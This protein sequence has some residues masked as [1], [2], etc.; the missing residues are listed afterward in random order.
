[1]GFEIKRRMYES[2]PLV[3]KRCVGL[4]PFSRVAGRAYRDALTRG[5]L[6]GRAGRAQILAYQEQALGQMLRFAT[7]QVP[8]YRSL[9]GCVERLP[10]FDALREFPLLDKEALQEH[11]ESYLPRDFERIPHYEIS[12]G[13]T[14]GRQ[15]RF[16]VDD[17][18][19][20]VET[21]F[22]HRQWGRVGY[23]PRC[24]KATFRGVSF[25][26]LKPGTHWQANPIYNEIQ[27]SPFH[28]TE[29][30]LA[31]YVDVLAR[32]N[33][34]YLHGYPSAVD[35]LAEYVLRNGLRERLPRIQAALLGSEGLMPG[36]R[37]RIEDAF[38][39]RVYSW[40][41]H[42]ERVILAGE[43]ELNETYHQFP[44]YGIMEIVSE[45]GKRLEREGER[46][47]L[48]G[49]GLLNR[50]LPLI[51]YRTGDYAT[52]CEPHCECGRS[53]DRFTAV[54]GRWKQEMLV[55]RNGA[56][57]SIA[58]LNMHGP[59]FER[60]IRYQYLQ[61]EAGVCE[62]RVLPAPGFSETDRLRIEDAYRAKVGGELELTVRA[63]DGISLTPRGKLPLLISTLGPGEDAGEGRVGALEAGVS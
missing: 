53:W 29:A 22:M 41:G 16:F 40:Y 4:V 38:Q 18:S 50:S 45:A 1:M 46:G 42:S 7:D 51:R 10:P 24:R 52:R 60:V 28:M 15:L 56:R 32:F 11:L 33:P 5:T 31:Q 9:R 6:F 30:N 35:I 13:G 62:L 48:V 26:N 58:A 36:Q 21:A 2:M 20:S 27:F 59:I 3:L 12:T 8:A 23:S 57:I 34:R 54:E 25:R 47:E 61:R 39:T 43:C 14:S 44:D 37:E 19:Q 17:A 49:T 55:G 63:V